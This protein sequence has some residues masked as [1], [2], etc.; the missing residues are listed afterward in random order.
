MDP[1]GQQRALLRKHLGLDCPTPDPNTTEK[2]LPKL[3]PIQPPTT[4][5]SIRHSN[6][7]F[8]IERCPPSSQTTKCA[9]NSCSR[10][11]TCGRY[12]VAVTPSMTELSPQ[13]AECK[14]FDYVLSKDEVPGVRSR[15]LTNPI[16]LYHISCF[17]KIADLSDPAYFTRIEPFTRHTGVGVPDGN[18]M[19]AGAVERLVIEWRLRRV[20]WKRM[21]ERRMEIMNKDMNVLQEGEDDDESDYEIEDQEMNDIEDIDESESIIDEFEDDEYGEIYEDEEDVSDEIQGTVSVS[22]INQHLSNP[23]FFDLWQNAGSSRFKSRGR[24]PGMQ[25]D[26]YN[27]LLKMLAPWESDGPNDTE[28]WNLF[29]TFMEKEDLSD[30]SIEKGFKGKKCDLSIMIEKWERWSELV[31]TPDVSLTHS[32]LLEKLSIGEKGRR[33][34]RR[35]A[36]IPMLQ[37]AWNF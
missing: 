30:L 11:F 8:F 7:S 24:V 32:Q 4:H 35:L 13:N 37:S 34:I 28:E 9:L 2:F 3:N 36:V 5:L 14:Y 18:Y 17:E 15:G 10:N 33:A 31:R 12:R 22:L 25:Q 16:D 29:D 27:L 20:R 23:L 26:Q 19:C 21:L 6:V 1:D